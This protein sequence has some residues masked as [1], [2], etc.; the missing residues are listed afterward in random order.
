MLRKSL[1]NLPKFFRKNSCQKGAS[2]VEFALIFPI[3]ATIIFTTIELGIMLAIKVNLQSCVMAGAYYGA[4]GSYTTGSTRTA[5]AQAVMT[6][7]IA[8][9]LN[10]ANLTL[11][12]QSF[13]T[14]ALASLGSAGTSGSGSA[15]Q[16]GMYQ[17][18]Y[19]YYPITPL[20]ATIFGTVHTL[21]ATTYTK[22]QGTFP[23]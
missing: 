20:V 7:G 12:I 22:N 14:F 3:L 4:T 11:T 16:V 5:S 8:G 1:S 10:M 9:F 17:A 21:T 18:Q 15:F 2:L 13:P 19:K 6:N 23:P